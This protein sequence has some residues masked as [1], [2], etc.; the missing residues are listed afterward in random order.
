[1]EGKRKEGRKEGWEEIEMRKERRKKEVRKGLE[2]IGG[3]LHRYG[4]EGDSTC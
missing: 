3:Y 1:M 4:S 2:W